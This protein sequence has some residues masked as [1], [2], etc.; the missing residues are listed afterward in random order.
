M[1]IA[2]KHKKDHHFKLWED[3]ITSC[4]F[5]PLSFFDVGEV[6]TL[7]RAW[8]PFSPDLWPSDTPTGVSISFWE[9]RDR[10]EPDI[11]FRFTRQGEPLLTVM[12]EVKWEAC[13]SGERQLV[14]QW[15]ALGASERKRALHVYLVK[16][17]AKGREEVEESLK[18]KAD[19]PKKEW[20]ERL[21]CVGW[22]DLIQVL[23]FDL[24]TCGPS[25]TLWAGSVQSFL[26]RRGLTTF[27]GFEWLTK[28]IELPEK[29]VFWKTV[30]WFSWLESGSIPRM[31][32][33]QVFWMS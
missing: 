9:K 5:G 29:E 10:F 33:G 30:P 18:E 12:F 20:Q 17:T 24:P 23:R 27:T 26:Q 13:Q 31:P 16:D 21:A 2:A 14:N 8:L 7:F 22:R 19:F 6:W 15:A 3:E 4:V 11:L 25:M 32:T 1:L 28:V